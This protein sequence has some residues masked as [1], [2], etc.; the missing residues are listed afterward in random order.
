MQRLLSSFYILNSSFYIPHVIRFLIRIVLMAALVA[1]MAKLIPQYFEVKGG[2]PAF[3]IIGVALALLNILVRPV[4]NILTFPLK[5]FAT[6]LAIVIANAAFLWFL[7]A[8]I[9]QL[10]PTLVQLQILGGAEGWIL[11]ALILGFG[12]WVV[13]EI[14]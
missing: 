7:E 3:A 13:K 10:D 2:I 4:L 14:L 6:I 11:V 9:A 5:L 1:I 8:T 12:N